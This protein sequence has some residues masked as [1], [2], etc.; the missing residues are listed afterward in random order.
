MHIKTIL[1]HVEKQPFFVYGKATLKRTGDM[2]GLHIRMQPRKGSKPHCSGCGICRPSYDR[3]DERTY[4]YLPLFVTL[5]VFLV[6]RPRR[7][8]CPRCGITVEM[9]PWAKGKSPITHALNWHLASW[10]KDLSW[11]QVARRFGVSWGVVFRAVKTAVESGLK[12]RSLD[13]IL[14]IGVDEI[15]RRKGQLYFTLVYQIDKGCRRLLWI[16]EDRKAATFDK[17]FDMMGQRSQS[18]A[19]VTSDMWKAYLSVIKKR[20]PWVVHV[21]DRFHVVKLSTEAVDET[22]REEVRALRAQ[23]KDPVLKDSRWLFLK[24]Q[25]NLTARQSPLLKDLL[26]LNLRTVKAYLL[27]EMLHGFWDKKTSKAGMTFLTNWCH[28]ATTSR[29]PAFKRLASTLKLHQ[30][31]LLNWFQAKDAFAKGAT[32]GLNNKS[33]V[34]TRRSYGFRTSKVAQIALFHALGKLPE[35]K[36]VT[37]RFG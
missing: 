11:M 24:N 16:G 21:L 29:L 1:N 32:E 31:L 22:R 15:A 30:E 9:V 17:F 28:S 33:K 5:A 36:W 37:H 13:G 10:A 35:P 12:L 7:C 3:I 20:A 8:D 25:V 27:K 19:Y 6:Y 14:A 23:G 18:I 34:I 26:R 4:Q 2:A